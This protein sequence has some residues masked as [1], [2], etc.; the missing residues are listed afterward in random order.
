M[1]FEQDWSGVEGVLQIDRI[2]GIVASRYS[3]EPGVE[4]FVPWQSSFMD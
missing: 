4:V 2:L 3:E 1:R